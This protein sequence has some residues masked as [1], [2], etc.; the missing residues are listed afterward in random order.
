MKKGWPVFESVSG[1]SFKSPIDLLIK[2]IPEALC[3]T[4]VGELH[5]H[6]NNGITWYICYMLFVMIFLAY[7]AIKKRDLFVNVL[8]FIVS[9][10]LLGYLS[11]IPFH[12]FTNTSCFIRA[13]CGLCFGVVAWNIFNKINEFN[14]T[15]KIRICL[16]V[17]EVFI[18][19]IFFFVLIAYGENADWVFPIL[20]LVP[21]AVAITFSQKSYVSNLFKAKCLRHLGTISLYFYLNHNISILVV[22]IILPNTGYGVSVLAAAFITAILCFANYIAG[23]IIKR[24]FNFIKTK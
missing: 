17:A 9:I 14:D 15:K 5:Y 7:L 23:R 10:I 1:E 12:V 8:S 22:T 11:N 18:Y 24:I 20:L 16:T 3:I 6:G 13:I 19:C 2:I 4:N 21:I